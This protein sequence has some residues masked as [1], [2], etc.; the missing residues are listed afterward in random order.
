MH[1]THTDARTADSDE[2]ATVEVNGQLAVGPVVDTG[3]D[4]E[5]Y[6][7]VRDAETGR[8]TVVRPAWP[9]HRVIERSEVAP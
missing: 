5:R 2:Y 9:G 4:R 8:E 6:L 1:T 3:Y 7:I